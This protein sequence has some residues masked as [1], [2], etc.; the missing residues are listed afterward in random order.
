MCVPDPLATGQ[1]AGKAVT[2]E[3]PFFIWIEVSFLFL[4]YFLL[5]LSGAAP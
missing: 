2:C 5:L 3:A 1:T 4:P